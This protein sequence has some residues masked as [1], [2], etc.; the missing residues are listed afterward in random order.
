MNAQATRANMA[1]LAQ[2]LSENIHARACLVTWESTVKQVLYYFC[3]DTYKKLLLVTGADGNSGV[4]GEGL[5]TQY[6]G[7][8][9]VL[10]KQ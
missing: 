8:A 5:F 6:R 4:E 3:N 10:Q 9:E 2:T 1:Q 7:S